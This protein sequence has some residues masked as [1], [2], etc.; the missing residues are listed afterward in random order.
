MFPDRG[1]SDRKTIYDWSLNRNLFLV[2]LTELQL[3]ISIAIGD[4]HKDK[5]LWPTGTAA[6]AYGHQRLLRG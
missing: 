3:R 5:L 6:L 1:G 2:R 4:H